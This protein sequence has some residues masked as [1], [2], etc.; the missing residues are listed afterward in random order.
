V[1]NIMLGTDTSRPAE[2]TC[3]QAALE[4][5]QDRRAQQYTI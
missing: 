3:G 4:D 5:G 2:R 1:V